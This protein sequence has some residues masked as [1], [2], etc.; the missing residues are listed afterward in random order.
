MHEELGR[1]WSENL[2]QPK[3]ALE[4]FRRSID[5]EPGSPYA[6]YARARSTSRKVSSTRRT[7]STTPS[8]RSRTTARASSRSSATKPRRASRRAISP[9]SRACCSRRARSTPKIPASR[10]STPARSSTACRRARTSRSRSAPRVGAPGAPRGA[11]RRRA[12]PRVFGRRA[13]RRSRPRSGAAALRVLCT[14]A[15]EGSGPHDEV[16]RLRAG[17]PQRR[18]ERRGAAHPGRELRGRGQIQNAIQMLEPLRALGD[19]SAQ[20]KLRELYPQASKTPSGAPPPGGMP[21]MQSDGSIPRAQKV[22][23]GES[24]LSVSSSYSAS[25]GQPASAR[26]MGA[27][28]PDKLQGVLDAAQMLANK[29]KK[30]E[31]FSKYKEVLETDASHPEA[32]S[33]IE[34]YLRTKRDYAQLRDVLLAAVRVMPTT[35]ETME[36]RKERLREVAGLCEGNLRDVGRRDLR[37]EA[38]SSPSTARTRGARTALMRLLEK[39]TALGRALRTSSSKRP[40]IESRRSRRRSSLE[41][42]LAKLQEDQA[43]SDLVGRWRG[44]GAHR[45]A[46][47][48]DDDQRDRSPRRSSSRRAISASTLAGERHRG[49]VLRAIDRPRRASGAADASVSRELREHDRRA[50]CR[51]RRLVRRGRRRSPQPASCG[52]TADRLLRRAAESWE[53]SAPTA[54]YRASRALESARLKVQAAVLRTCSGATS[55]ARTARTTASSSRLE[56]ATESRS[57]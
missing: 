31:A 32:L 29:G 35:G 49:Q 17:Q 52:T 22:P 30:A 3:K 7:R 14:S 41:K 57:D 37:L 4:N 27:L 18:D 54:A 33:W 56:D 34:E 23:S 44:L 2:A 48:T 26:K 9:A 20:A 6:I 45:A 43:A 10:R 1:L 21:P 46:S 25:F 42:K 50:R 40:P 12:R 5:L 55:R 11:V 13:G 53:K 15:A 38:S 24:S 19:Q 51:R 36:A 39:S 47:R 28:T 16:P 8:C